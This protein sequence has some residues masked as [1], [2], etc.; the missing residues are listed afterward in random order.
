MKKISIFSIIALI[1]SLISCDYNDDNFPG[2]DN[3]K[4]TDVGQYDGVFDR[5]YPDGGYFTDK[6]E[7]ES[8]INTMLKDSILYPDKGYKASITIMFGD[9]TPGFSREDVAYTLVDADYDSMGEENGQPG[10]YNNFDNKMDVDGYLIDFIT[11][12]YA[13]LV[14]GKIVSIT[15][16]YYETGAGTNARTNSYKKEVSGWYRIELNAFAADISYK[17][18]TEDYDAMGTESGKPGRY[19]NFDANMDINQYLDVMLRQKYPYAAVNSTA[20]V[21]YDYYASTTTS[22]SSYYRFDGIRWGAFDPYADTIDVT[23]KIAEM[24]FNGTSWVLDRLLGGSYKYSLTIP[25]CGKLLDWVKINKPEYVSVQYDNEEF[26]FGASAHY[27]N[28]NNDY[29]KWKETYNKNGE[30]TGKTDD[31]VQLIMDER[32]AWGISNLILP[33]LISTPDPGVSYQ[34]T[35]NVYKGRG[36]GDYMQ[37]FMYNEEE[38]KYE[39]V[40]SV[41]V[42]Q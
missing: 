3:A 27:G 35:Y 12:K 39:V 21:T 8:A 37:A 17:M 33:D 11:Q 40:S 29:A 30:F 9:V 1:A 23:A 4:L 31:Q 15:Y 7:V 42:K 13:S 20:M 16:M 19:D 34:I 14:Q 26:Y 18:V 28:I 22:R 2:Y 5:S 10:K 32:I 25:D 24:E 6:T 36:T 38:G 41:P